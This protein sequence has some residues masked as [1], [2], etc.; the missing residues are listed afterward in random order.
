MSSD[1]DYNEFRYDAA[2]KVGGEYT[3][4]DTVD[5][6][7]GNPSEAQHDYR[8]EKPTWA[9]TRTFTYPPTDEEQAAVRPSDELLAEARITV[10]FDG[11]RLVDSPLGEFFGTGL[12]LYE[13]RSLMYGVDPDTKTLSSWWP[14][15]YSNR[16]KV[17]LH[18]DSDVAIKGGSASVTTA[19]DSRWAQALGDSGTAGHFRTTSRAQTVKNNG[20][21]YTFLNATG[22]GKFVGV[23]HT[24]RGHVASGNQ[25]E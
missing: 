8:I 4:T 16:L 13:V 2:S 25:R 1:L 19:A 6:G 17:E 12:G 21:D 5:V 20:V 18:N 14:M 11:R 15:P 24:M 22:R 10:S 3:R 7:E 23:T 9:G